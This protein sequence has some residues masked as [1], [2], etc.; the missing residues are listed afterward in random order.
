MTWSAP[1]ALRLGDLV[2]AADGGDHG[3]AGRLGKLD[4][5]GAD[6]AAAGLDQDGLA[7]A[8]LGVVEQ[9]MLGRAVGD[10]RAGRGDDA[11]AGRRRDGQ[12]RREVD[13]ARAPARRCESRGC[14]GRSRRNCRAR[15]GM[16]RRRRRS[17]RRRSRRRRLGARRSTPSPTRSDRARR[18]DPDDDR[19]L[20]LG[21]RHAAPAPHVDVV[22][23]DRAD[24]DLHLAGGGRRRLGKLDD[25]ELAAVE[26]LERAHQAL[27]GRNRPRAERIPP[28]LARKPSRVNVRNT[29]AGRGYSA[30]PGHA[31][32]AV[33]IRQAFWPPKPKELE[34]TVDDLLLAGVV[35]HDVERD[36]RIGDLVVDRRRNDAGAHGLHR[37]HRLDRA[38]RGERVADHRLVRADRHAAQALAE[39]L[40]ERHRLHLVVLRRAG[41]V[42]VDVLD[43]VRRR[44]RHPRRCCGARR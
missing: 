39:H 30:R 28:E 35:R 25:R 18:L 6:A 24:P 9:H 4:R 42:G 22:Q 11:D 16:A 43:L 31:G 5:G 17:R 20:A 36:G 15:R 26:N 2:V 13:R 14:R 21:E 10:R 33:M 27:E 23:R 37:E 34:R 38:R 8:E 19:Q 29:P 41:A 1:I 12:A 40:L 3:G 32:S 44:C 7:G